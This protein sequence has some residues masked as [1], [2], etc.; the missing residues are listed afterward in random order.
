[1][2]NFLP[3]LVLQIV[4]FHVERHPN[5]TWYEQCVA[6]NMFPTKLHELTY[7]VLG[8]AMMYGLPLVVIIISYACIIAEILR[9][10]QLSLDGRLPCSAAVPFHSLLLAL[11]IYCFV[12]EFLSSSIFTYRYIYLLIYNC[13]S[14]HLYTQTHRVGAPQFNHNIRYC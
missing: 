6:F 2:K 1:L 4:I 10:Y 7:R 12:S 11:Y 9:R 3:R 14:Y 13:L 5:V 8:M